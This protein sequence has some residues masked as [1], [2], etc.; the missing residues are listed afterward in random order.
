MTESNQNNPQP[1][2]KHLDYKRLIPLA[3]II[4]ALGLAYYFRLYEYLSYQAIKDNRQALIAWTNEHYILVVLSFMAIYIVS[5]AL[6]LPGA[7]FL[8]LASGCLFGIVLGTIYVVISATIGATAI[9]L[10]VQWSLGEWLAD[11]ATSWINT[12]RQGF[13][14]DAF[15][16][17]L[18]LRLV[19]IFPFWV[20]NI[21][22]ALLNVKRSQFILATG[23]GIMPGSLVYVMIG[24]G[25]GHLLD[26][27][28]KPDLGII[29]QP[30]ILLPLIGLGILALLPT[31]Y[32][33]FK[34]RRHDAKGTE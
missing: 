3:I 5:T 10:A 9:F 25:L 14:R 2:K 7:V 20:V 16:Y 12:L 17:L 24:N 27:G 30:Q 6:S 19:P 26:Q 1:P 22:P 8:T 15:Q 33:Q 29:F 32:K 28:K 4:I 23:L 31:I 11:K 13:Q 34:R 18:F 21:V